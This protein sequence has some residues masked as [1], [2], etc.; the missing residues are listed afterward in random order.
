MDFGANKTLIEV[1]KAGEFGGTYFRDIYSSV[2]VQC[3]ENHGKNLM[4]WKNIGQKSYCSSYYD[5]SVNKYGVKC[6]KSQ[7]FW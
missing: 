5:V 6:R 4:S 7:R 2:N 3:T 1:I